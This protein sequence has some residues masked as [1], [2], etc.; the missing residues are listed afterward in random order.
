MD[1]INLL[2]T[3]GDK[4]LIAFDEA[5]NPRHVPRTKLDP[6]MMTIPCAGAGVT[7]HPH[8]GSTLAAE[9][10]RRPSIATKLIPLEGVKLHQD[11]DFEKTFLFDVSLFEAVAAIVKAKKRRRVTPTQ[12]AALLKHQRRFEVGAQ[13][14]T[15]E[16]AQAPEADS[17]AALAS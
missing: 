11:G 17:G 12:L 7:I 6:W 4:Y 2:E 9:V 13:K 16:R 5:Y 10:N 8:G 3:F 14:S 1:C 15:L